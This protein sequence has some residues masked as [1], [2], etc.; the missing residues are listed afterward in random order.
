MVLS[1]T[2]T[3]YSIGMKIS[4]SVLDL[5][6]IKITTMVQHNFGQSEHLSRITISLAWLFT[7]KEHA[8]EVLGRYYRCDILWKVTNSSYYILINLGILQNS[9]RNGFLV[10]C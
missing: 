5:K 10:R 6:V 7:G 2:E 4:V 3:M 1:Q 9:Y 8:L